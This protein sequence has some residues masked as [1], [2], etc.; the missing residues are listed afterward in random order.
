MHSTDID[1][2]GWTEDEKAAL[3]GALSEAELWAVARVEAESRSPADIIAAKRREAQAAKRA[4][5]LA[6]R[7]READAAF[8]KACDEHGPDRVGRIRTVEGS[9]IIRAMTGDEVD[10]SMSAPTE[11]LSR[12]EQVKLARAEIKRLLVYPAPEV[13][14]ERAQK[15]FPGLW[16]E[17]FFLRDLL[18]SGVRADIE[19][20][21]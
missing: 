9:V 19:K 3:E 10:R 16:T 17:L 2:T 5:E 11:G 6:H 13:L 1:T 7:E 20:K 8:V 12:L 15:R 4:A 18:T 21:G 14:E